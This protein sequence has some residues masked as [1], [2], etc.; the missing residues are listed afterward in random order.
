[1]KFPEI[2]KKKSVSGNKRRTINKCNIALPKVFPK[3]KKYLENK[4]KKLIEKLT[5]EKRT[6]NKLSIWG[7]TKK[8]I[9]NPKNIISKI[10]QLS[11]FSTTTNQKS[12]QFKKKKNEDFDK[13]SKKIINKALAILN[14]RKKIVN[15]NIEKETILE[16]VEKTKEVYL[17]KMTT[18][19]V[20][21][22]INRLESNIIQ[23]KKKIDEYIKKQRN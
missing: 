16:K 17:I 18:A 8:S 13:Q 4:R 21:K 5:K 20:N 14:N 11:K 23:N 1:M 9:I 12:I 15:K 6:K 7:K 10:S 3:S 22:E 19:I 2:K